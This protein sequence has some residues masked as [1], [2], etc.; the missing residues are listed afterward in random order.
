MGSGSNG[1]L[2]AFAAWLMTSFCLAAV[3]LVVHPIAFAYAYRFGRTGLASRGVRAC[4]AL[5][6]FLDLGVIAAGWIHNDWV[7][8]LLTYFGGIAPGLLAILV[9]CW[10]LGRAAAP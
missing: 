9:A 2:E 8:L 7:D 6:V 5:T 3:F 1:Q 10:A 4:L